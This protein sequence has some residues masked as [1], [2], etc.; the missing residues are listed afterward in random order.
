VIYRAIK[1][2][3]ALALLVAVASVLAHAFPGLVGADYSYV[4]QS[5]SMEPAIGTGSVI[6]VNDV[7]ADDV[8]EGDVITFSKSAGA[9]TT[10]HRVVEK[11]E[12]GNSVRFVTKG[13]ANEDPDPEPVYRNE[14]VGV[15]TFSLPLVGYVIGF[16]QTRLGWLVLVAG[17]VALLIASELWELYRAMEIEE[18][19]DS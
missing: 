15:T 14:I 4:V 17:P 8:E 12:A 3:A 10:T 6:F 19:S 13:D 9:P 7:P 1:A 2:V 5:G 11:H 18:A 16:A